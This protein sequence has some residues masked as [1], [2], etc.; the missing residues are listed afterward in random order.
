MPPMCRRYAAHVPRLCRSADLH[1]LFQFWATPTN[2]GQ[3]L[4]E[5]GWFGPSAGNL[6]VGQLWPNLPQVRLAGNRPSSAGSG[7]WPKSGQF[8]LSSV[9]VGLSSAGFPNAGR[10]WP[11]SPELGPRLAEF[12]QTPDRIGPAR[13]RYLVK[14]GPAA[15]ER[16]AGDTWAAHDRNDDQRRW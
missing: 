16:A 14:I 3:T 6:G 12:G 15:H 9:K 5:G 4:T 1:V 2:V 8:W 10:I 11:N 13:A 7:H